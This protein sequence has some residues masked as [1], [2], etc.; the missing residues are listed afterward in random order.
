L[1]DVWE[2]QI[3]GPAT[4]YLLALVNMGNSKEEAQKL[5]STIPPIYDIA[6]EDDYQLLA[7]RDEIRVFW[8]ELEKERTNEGASN[9]YGDSAKVAVILHK[10][11]KHYNLDSEGY[12]VFWETGRFFPTQRNFRGLIARILVDRSRYLAICPRCSQ[13]FIKRR[14]DQKNCLSTDCQRAANRDRQEKFQGNRRSSAH[15]S[16]RRAQS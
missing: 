9:S 3:E 11:W 4:R 13:R 5:R 2:Q 16:R 12:L 1:K 15:K 14:D 10:W 8:D 7:L 6:H